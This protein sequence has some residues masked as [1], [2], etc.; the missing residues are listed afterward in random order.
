MS[1]LEHINSTNPGI[2][3]SKTLK[4]LEAAPEDG[5]SV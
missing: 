4:E 5:L 3:A 1:H 2:I